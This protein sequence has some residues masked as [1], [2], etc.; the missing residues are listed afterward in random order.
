MKVSVEFGNEI[1]TGK[2]RYCLGIGDR[3][4]SISGFRRRK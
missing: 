3:N 2:F 4:L 1:V